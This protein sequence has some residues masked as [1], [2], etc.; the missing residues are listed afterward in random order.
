MT[1]NNKIHLTLAADNNYAQHMGV[2][3]ISVLENSKYKED[4]VFHVIENSISKTNI[5]KI[6]SIATKYKCKIN[7]YKIDI[8]KT[9]NFPEYNH[10]TKAAYYRLFVHELLPSDIEKVIYLDCDIVALGEVK[11]LYDIDVTNYMFAAVEDVKS[12]QILKNYFYLNVKKY[13][14]S[15]VL[16][17]NLNKWRER[18]DMEYVYQ[19]VH[20]YKQEIKTQ[21]QDILNCLFSNEWLELERRFNYD[22]KHELNKPDTKKITFLHYTS[23]IKPW[24]YLYVG[25][26]KSHYFKYLKISPWSDFIIKDKSFVNMLRKYLIHYIKSIK[27]VLRPLIP[28]KLIALKNR[29]FSK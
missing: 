25:K 3:I 8:E 17:I 22:A 20:K 9:S 27:N 2:A 11:E 12:K 13:F 26:I 19:F 28:A 29:I 15:G 10:L 21:D 7:F 14:N 5:R 23:W 4:L 16:L 18:L 1:S 6:E 24:S